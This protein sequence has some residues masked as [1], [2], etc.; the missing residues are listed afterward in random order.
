MVSTPSVK[1]PEISEPWLVI[2]P[3]YLYV[4]VLLVLSSQVSEVLSE[5][6]QMICHSF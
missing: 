3:P 1:G 4:D 5:E 6:K 2:L